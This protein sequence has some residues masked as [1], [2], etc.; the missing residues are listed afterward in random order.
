L[1]ASLGSF[2]GH[3]EGFSGT[4]EG[5]N[6]GGEDFRSTLES[7]NRPEDGCFGAELALKTG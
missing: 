1:S 6:G 4:W 7:V 5:F 3:R 2:T